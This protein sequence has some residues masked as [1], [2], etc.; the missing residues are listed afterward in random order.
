MT[1]AA[2]SAAHLGRRIQNP[3]TWSLRRRLLVV[4]ALLFAVLTAA[5]A[6]ASVMTMRV[7]LESRVDEQLHE[8]SERT[9]VAVERALA[10]NVT[11]TLDPRMS[12][13]LVVVEHGGDLLNYEI[14]TRSGAKQ[15]LSGADVEAVIGAPVGEPTNAALPGYGTYRVMATDVGD[16]RVI[17]GMSL[18]DTNQTLAALAFVIAVAAIAAV[19]IVLLMGDVIIRRALRPLTSVIATTERISQLPL[20]SG[21]A[22][23][24]NRVRIEEPA[25]EVGR[26]QESMNRMLTHIEE[27]FEAR[28][29]S[30]RRVRQ[31]VADA[32]H[33]LR[34]P[35]AAVRG[36]AEITQ[37]HE[38]NLS[39]DSR[40]SLE[41]IEAAAHRMQALV[42]DLL[43]LARLDEGRE[44]ERGEVDLSLLV[45][46]AVADAQAAGDGHPISLE[47]PEQP[48]VVGGDPL[49]LQQIVANLLA[50]ARVH[51]PPGTAIDVH[52]RA[53]GG[54]AVIDVIDA[55]PGIPEQLQQTVFQR[56]A[57]GDSS[58]SRATGSSGLGLAI[59]QALVDAHHGSISLESVPGRTAF[60]V[61]LP[62]WQSAAR[63]EA[64]VGSD[65]GGSAG[66]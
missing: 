52:L 22:Q 35:L 49:R 59:V 53:E 6:I 43:L 11:Q 16:A 55:G 39:D 31:F 63:G 8:L 29:V 64:P 65:V 45:V 24:T 18:S 14:F 42:D 56:F 7:V 30:E 2:A 3:A 38:A 21:D 57:R 23:L 25:S 5:V 33:E 9:S 15:A 61:R 1:Q 28:A 36:Y 4:V 47:L 20:A 60:S 48:V 50:N 12:G 27:A 46:E 37:K 51:T 10:T 66:E 26:V 62:L 17:V 34:T 41:R 32:S 54:D 19:T 13:A 40:A 58:R 44:I